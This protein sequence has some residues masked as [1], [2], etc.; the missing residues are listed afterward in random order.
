MKIRPYTAKYTTTVTAM[1]TTAIHDNRLKCIDGVA[2]TADLRNDLPEDQNDD[3]QIRG[4][5]SAMDLRGSS[6]DLWHLGRLRVGSAVRR[7]VV[8]IVSHTSSLP[9]PDPPGS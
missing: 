2:I 9:Y 7:G 8:D 5:P 1:I 6:I 4:A 3:A